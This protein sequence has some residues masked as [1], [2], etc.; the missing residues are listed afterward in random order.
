MTRGQGSTSQ[1]WHKLKH[2]ALASLLAFSAQRNSILNIQFP[3]PEAGCPVLQ[4]EVLNESRN[5]KSHFCFSTLPFKS[6]S[7]NV[8]QA[9]QPQHTLLPTPPSLFHSYFCPWYKLFSKALRLDTLALCLSV[10]CSS[11]L[12]LV[13]CH[14]LFSTITTTTLTQALVIYGL[15]YWVISY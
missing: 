2:P 13:H 14:F 6:N 7:L 8:L 10:L 3:A 1:I 4:L 12:Q 5:P 15:D 11:I 9:P